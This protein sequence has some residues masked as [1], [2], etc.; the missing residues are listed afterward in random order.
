MGWTGFGV[1]VCVLSMGM[2][3]NPAVSQQPE[4]PIWIIE[5]SDSTLYMIG[6]VHVMREGIDA[7]GGLGH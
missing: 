2:A 7:K 3:A 6:T 4:P 5:D 1:A